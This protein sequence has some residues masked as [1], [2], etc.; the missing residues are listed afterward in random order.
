M[1]GRESSEP[2]DVARAFLSA[3]AWGEHTTVWETLSTQARLA[4]LHVA[5]RRGLDPRL[6][7]RLREGTAGAVERD[8]FLSDLLHGLR[9][10]LAGVDLEALGC[11]LGGPGSTVDGSVL[12]HLVT[13][14]PPE[15]GD[16]LPAGRV[17]LVLDSGR[18]S[19][20]RLDGVR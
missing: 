7:A 2:L 18:W 3:I 13:D 15:L 16:P 10:E 9:S 12:V 14:V 8:E 17:E 6:S 5:E 11:V 1:T 4:V 20:V 19:V